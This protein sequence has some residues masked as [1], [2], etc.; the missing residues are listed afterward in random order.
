MSELKTEVQ[1]PSVFCLYCN[2][3]IVNE[4]GRKCEYCI[5]YFCASCEGQGKANWHYPVSHPSITMDKRYSLHRNL[6]NVQDDRDK[7]ADFA[8]NHP[9][10]DDIDVSEPK[11]VVEHSWSRPR[12]SDDGDR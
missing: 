2:Q 12:P 7:L 1:K 11:N 5:V 3:R 10:N 8:K 9:N 4:D 6:I